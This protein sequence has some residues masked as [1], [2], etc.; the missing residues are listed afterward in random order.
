MRVS[1]KNLKVVLCLVAVFACASVAPAQTKNQDPK[2]RLAQT[3]EQAGKC[4]EAAKIYEELRATE[5]TNIVFFD[6]L[7]RMY[8]QLKR[9]DDAVA[10]LRDR[11]ASHPADVTLRAQLGS[12]LYKAGRE[13]EAYTEWEHALTMDPDNPAYYRTVASVLMENRLL[14]KT[15][16]LYRRARVACGDSELFTLELAQLLSLSMDF[17]GATAEYLRWLKKNPK[18]LAF[19]E[20]RMAGITLREEAL[21]AAIEEVRSVLKR[22]QEDYLFEFLAWLHL[23]EKDYDQA[24]EVYKRLNRMS[25]GNGTRI[26]AFAERAFREKAFRIAAQAY[27]EAINTPLPAGRVPAAKFG[28][29]RCLKELS[30]LSDT[31]RTRGSESGALS[32]E[33]HPQYAEAIEY[34]QKIIKE[35]PRSE[36]SARSYFEVGVLQ[37]ERLFDNDAALVSLLAV[38]QEMPEKSTLSSS[39]ALNISKVQTAKGDTSSAASRLRVVAV[40]SY[41]TPDQQDE[42]TYRLAEL[43]YFRGE[44]ESATARLSEITLNLHADYANDALRLR[45]F[46]EENGPAGNTPVKEFARAEYLMRQRKN[47]EAVALFQ[48]VLEQYPQALLVDDALMNVGKLQSDAGLYTEAISTYEGL[49]T[50]FAATSIVLDRALFSIGEICQFGLNNKERATAAYEKLLADF[51]RSLYVTEARKRIRELR[52]ESS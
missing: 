33:A 32:G 7:R 51:P 11:L 40:A 48:T 19:V 10:L 44:F 5:P 46:L 47:T 29:A 36:F 23:E 26:H 21:R 16:E 3:Y 43:E 37:F 24:Y 20:N 39:V 8:L 17:R 34:F 27:L 38:E 15:A 45:A 50:D 13:A 2:I 28:Y 35:Y 22:E 41:A 6:G 4:E 52:G 1:T 9:Y 31:P 12:V 49:L 14:D 18:Q 42:A 25:N 30:I